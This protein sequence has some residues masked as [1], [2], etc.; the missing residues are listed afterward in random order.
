[1]AARTGSKS[2]PLIAAGGHGARAPVKGRAARDESLACGARIRCA[3][4]RLGR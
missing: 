4:M 3:A 1:L 2:A